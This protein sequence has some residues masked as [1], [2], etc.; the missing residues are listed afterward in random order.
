MEDQ[1]GQRVWKGAQGMSMGDTIGMLLD[2]DAGSMT[3]FKNGQ[4]LGIMAQNLAGP[5]V[6]GIDFDHAA[7]GVRIEAK[8]PPKSTSAAA[9]EPSVQAQAEPEPELEPEEDR[10]VDCP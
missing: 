9:P 5:L 7:H 10:G 2:L 1:V 8:A 4:R 6:W 3:V